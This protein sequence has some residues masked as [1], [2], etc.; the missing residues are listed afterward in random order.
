[1]LCV[2]L[3]FHLLFCFYLPKE[4][5]MYMLWLLFIFCRNKQFQL[6]RYASDHQNSLCLFMNFCCLLLLK[7]QTFSSRLNWFVEFSSVLSRKVWF[8]L[9]VPV[10]A[11][12]EYFL[13]VIFLLTMSKVDFMHTENNWSRFYCHPSSSAKTLH[14]C[15]LLKISSSICTLS[16]LDPPIGYWRALYLLNELQFDRNDLCHLME[17]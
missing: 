2:L 9:V 5:C 7:L 10:S 3:L 17:L 12:F 11:I 14:S 15:Q 13:S 6:S 8:S 1:M 4:T 16:Y